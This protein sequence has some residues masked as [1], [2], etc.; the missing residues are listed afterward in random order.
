[1]VMVSCLRDEATYWRIRIAI[2]LLHVPRFF[3]TKEKNIAKDIIVFL[4]WQCCWS[5][6]I[7]P[8][9]LGTADLGNRTSVKWFEL[10]P[11][12]IFRAFLIFKSISV[13]VIS[14]LGL[15][16]LISP[17]ILEYTDCKMGTSELDIPVMEPTPKSKIL[18]HLSL[19]TNLGQLRA[20]AASS[21]G[22]KLPPET[23]I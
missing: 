3:I 6:I 22:Q 8:Q 12:A 14:K 1:M 2:A 4:T 19:Q 20:A 18:N 21:H 7:H 17:F 16:I 11:T 9:N 10:L 23:A 5:Q 15:W 13:T